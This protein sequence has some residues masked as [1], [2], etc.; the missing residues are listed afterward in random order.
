VLRALV[1]AAPVDGEPAAVRAVAE[2]SYAEAYGAA[3][4]PA[5]AVAGELG[6]APASPLLLRAAQGSAGAAAPPSGDPARPPV[7]PPPPAR[8]AAAAPAA[9]APALPPLERR[10]RVPLI[11]RAVGGAALLIVL[12]VLVTGGADAP[13]TTAPAART[14][15]VTATGG[16]G[17]AGPPVARGL[18]REPIT[19]SGA[20][21]E[22]APIVN[23][24]WARQI[25]RGETRR[26]YRWVTIS[27]RAR[28]LTRRS[29]AV[30]GLG[31]RLLTR[32]GVIVG[33][34][35]VDLAEATVGVR[36]GR[37][38]VGAQASVHLGFEVPADARRGLTFAFEPGGLEDPTVIVP[39]PDLT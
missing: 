7:P 37:L 19:A 13:R 9:A 5:T 24:K 15:T 38:A 11:W 30:S 28:D 20:R 17:T 18:P 39:L 6:L 25:R 1:E 33:P 10:K 36:K 3:A 21:F 8:P 16:A 22:V 34:A 29:L 4:E 23:A 31:Y 26:G 35:V 14:V 32:A 27:V 12:I 2:R